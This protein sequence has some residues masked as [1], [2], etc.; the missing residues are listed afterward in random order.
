MSIKV[1][2]SV[3]ELL[4]KITI[5]QIKAERSEN[6]FI[7]KELEDLIKI[8][9]NNGIYHLDYLLEL[10]E[11]N[12]KLWEIE[13]ELR[14]MEKNKLFNE[15]FIELARSVYKYNDTRANIKKRI[16]EETNSTYQEVKLYK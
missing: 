13:D 10:K 4:D 6:I 11:V 9:K 7:H 12:L 16:N 15:I 1:P 8:A 2:V 3:G 5:L 14:D